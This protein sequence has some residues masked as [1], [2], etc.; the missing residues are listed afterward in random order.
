MTTLTLPQ[1]G[2]RSRF[3]M[4]G[5]G[6]LILIWLSLEDTSSLSVAFLGT[7]LAFLIL[8]FSLLN[9]I[10]GQSFSLKQSFFGIIILGAFTGALA[11]IC[12]TLLMFFKSSWHGHQFLDYPPQMMLAM[13]SRA[14][15]WSVA[16]LLMGLAIGIF[17][18]LRT[19][20][21]AS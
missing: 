6:L 8:V 16:G 19:T 4:I 17:V 7:G 12:T 11:A 20:S 2:S 10:G 9:R 1:L 18:V 5:Y 3:A 21:S 15:A 13:L 14:L